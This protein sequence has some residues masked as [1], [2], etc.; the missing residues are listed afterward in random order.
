MV[1]AIAGL[2][3]AEILRYGY[4]IEYDYA[5]PTQLDGHA[6]DQGRA[7][8]CSWPGRSTAPPA[9][10]RPPAQ[11][12]M[13][14]HQ[15]RPAAARAGAAGPA[16]RPGVHRRDDRRP[17][18]QG[19]HRA[20]P[21]VHQPGRAPPE[22]AGRQRRPA[23]DRQ[24]GRSAGLVDEDRWHRFSQYKQAA[25]DTRQRRVGLRVAGQ[26]A[27]EAPGQPQ[28]GARRF[29]GAGRGATD[30]QRDPSTGGRLT[31]PRWRPVVTDCRYAGYVERQQRQAQQLAELEQRTIPEAMDYSA[32]PHLRAEARQ[33]LF[34][35]R[36]RTLGQA[37]R[38]TGITPADITVLSIHLHALK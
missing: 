17:G 8:A 22:P 28:H 18:D 7:R 27:A 32:V 33:R 31:Q 12:L 16:A 24:L 15:R 36:P 4:A 20:V 2:E 37:L 25:D 29:A 19:R 21:H 14:G 34:E 11:G 30:G 10:R 5:P 6:G 35:I 26:S 9:T 3:R 1:R 23:A 38:I 13:A